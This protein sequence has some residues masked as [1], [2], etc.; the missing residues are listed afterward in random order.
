M[1]KMSTTVI[2]DFSLSFTEQIFCDGG[3]GWQETLIWCRKNDSSF[4]ESKN[5]KWI[6]G[7]Y[8]KMRLTAVVVVVVAS[9]SVSFSVIQQC[10]LRNV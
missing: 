6:S 1:E 8:D 9:V 5:K 7:F 10:D 2:F 4:T 3:D